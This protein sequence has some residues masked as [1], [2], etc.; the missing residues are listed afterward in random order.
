MINEENLVLSGC[1]SDATKEKFH[2]RACFRLTNSRPN[3]P[4][5]RYET[6]VN[7][8]F[9]ISKEKE[10]KK[11]EKKRLSQLWIRASA[12][13]CRSFNSPSHSSASMR[14]RA[15]HV[16]ILRSGAIHVS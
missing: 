9:D 14:A 3:E 11:R 12:L 10:K 16:N 7:S 15:S 6:E 8:R 4:I 1:I 2:N 13:N 5:A